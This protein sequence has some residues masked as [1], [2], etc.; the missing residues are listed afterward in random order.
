MNTIAQRSAQVATKFLR[1]S[2]DRDER[3]T[4]AHA[5]TLSISTGSETLYINQA[6]I[7]TRRKIAVLDRS[8][9]NILNVCPVR[10]S[11]AVT[12]RGVSGFILN[13]CSTTPSLGTAKTTGVMYIINC[14]PSG[15]SRPISV[16]RI[17]IGVRKSPTD[18]PAIISVSIARGRREI[19]QL[20]LTPKIIRTGII[21]AIFI[22]ALK[23]V[24]KKPLRINA[25]LGKFNFANMAFDAFTCCRGACR[26]S[27]KTC[28]SIVP[29][30]TYT[31]YGIPVSAIRT[32]PE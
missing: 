16:Y 5:L 10:I 2:I 17:P 20:G 27:V 11:R 29:D 26:A 13:N 28:Q 19:V 9:Y 8:S 3:F 25:S 24:L 14:A 22:D 12:I 30:K 23:K 31:A 15:N 18:I 4:S 32:I 6:K 1:N 21:I 7:R